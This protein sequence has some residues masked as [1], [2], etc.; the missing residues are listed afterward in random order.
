MWLGAYAMRSIFAALIASL[1]LGAT[2]AGAAEKLWDFTVSPTV[3]VQ[4]LP[5]TA[6][7]RSVTLERAFL[8]MPEGA[9]WATYVQGGAINIGK[10][11]LYWEGR[12]SDID[13]SDLRPEFAGVLSAAGFGTSAKRELFETDSKGDLQIGAVISNVGGRLCWGCGMGVPY[14]HYRGATAMSV[15]WQIYSPLDRKVLATVR[16]TGSFETKDNRPG[17]GHILNGAFRENVR[18]LL[19]AAEFRAVVFGAPSTTAR[20]SSEGASPIRV[21]LSARKPRTIPN[22]TTSVV[23]VFSSG[24]MGS[25]FLIT[26]DGYVLTNQHVVGDSKFVKVKWSDGIEGLGEVVRM[27]RRRDVALIKVSAPKQAALALRRT[28]P[29]VGEAVFAIGTPLDEKFQGSVTKGIVSA[30]RTYEGMSY[31]Q[32]DVVINN[33]NSG[34]P[35][36]DEQGAVIGITV[37]GIDIGGAPAGIN[38]FIPI[39]DALKALA[40]T[41]AT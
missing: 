23:S 36:L 37:S 33:G 41:P 11:F 13:I 15:E 4:P 21:S 3:A 8:D 14:T 39:D 19:N 31:I 26:A 1:A 29:Q 35:L 28:A 34:G 24:A 18:Q 5:A 9:E 17:V 32:S 22:A 16:T 6:K 2:S 38:L 30:T 10:N 7:P 27:D 40:L 20:A 25:G 12:R